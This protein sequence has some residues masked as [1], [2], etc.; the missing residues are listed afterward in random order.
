MEVEWD[1]EPKT[2]IAVKGDISIK[3]TID[4]NIAIVNGKE[5]TLD[6]PAEVTQNRTFVP[7]RFFAEALNLIVDWNG[8]T[9]TVIIK[10]K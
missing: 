1:G 9:K 7:V 4:S 5:Q 2:A 10:S 6:V 3:I 8:N